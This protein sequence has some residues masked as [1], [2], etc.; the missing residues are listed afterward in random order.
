MPV[1]Y[2]YVNEFSFTQKL[3]RLSWNICR[4]LFFKT[5][6]PRIRFFNSW[7]VFLLKL[8]GVRTC[9]RCV[10]FPSVNIWAPWNLSTGCGVA[11][12]ENVDIYNV[13]PIKIGHFVSISRRA[14]LC[15]ASHDISDVRRPLIYKPITVGNG[16]WI[17]ADAIICPGVTIGEG[18][19][20]A[21]G[22]VVTKDVPSWSVVGGNPAKFIK[23]RPVNK[24]E[25][26]EV[27]NEME[28]IFKAQN[29]TNLR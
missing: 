26:I 4:V 12:D 16:V 28:E 25:W 5:T 11:I 6:F 23:E 10:F 7:R 3:C 17:G 8:W 21:A 20:V 27:F 15:T 24:A 2:K 1:D 13:A 14:F 18:A 9:S 29:K 22:A 19:V